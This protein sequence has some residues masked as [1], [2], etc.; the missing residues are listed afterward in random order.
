MDKTLK[1]RRDAL[2]VSYREEHRQSESEEISF[3][4][5][6][7]NLLTPSILH[8]AGCDL[9]SHAISIAILQSKTCEAQ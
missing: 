8:A 3:G 4:T 2:R 1:T 7:T 6:K 5:V 9:R